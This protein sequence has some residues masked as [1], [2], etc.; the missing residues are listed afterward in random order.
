MSPDSRKHVISILL[1]NEAGVLSRVAGLFSARGYNIASLTV[2]PTTDPLLSRITIVTRG[3]DEQAK[4]IVKQLRKLVDV[5]DVVDLGK[6]QHVETEV[7][8]VKVVCA[9]GRRKELDALVKRYN[10]C[11]VD[12]RASQ[13]VVEMTSEGGEI[14]KFILELERVWEIKEVARSGII[15]LGSGNLILAI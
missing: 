2:A 5:V 13:C 4:Q 8:L 11:V 7:V 10:A 12:A 1:A 14:D 15:S 6:D 9:D 3:R